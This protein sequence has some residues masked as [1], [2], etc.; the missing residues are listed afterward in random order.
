[1]ATGSMEPT[2]KVGAHYFVNKV[3]Y[4]R[5]LPLRGEIIVLED[6]LDPKKGMIKRVIAIEGDRIARRAKAVYLNDLLLSEPYAVYSR[7]NDPLVGDNF[8]PLVVPKGCVFV[9]GDNRDESEDSSVWTDPQ[10]GDPI[11]FIKHEKIQG[12]LIIL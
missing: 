12:R 6:P 7:P 2:L 8:N 9:L 3:A 4:L 1:M 10:T 5:K 11:R